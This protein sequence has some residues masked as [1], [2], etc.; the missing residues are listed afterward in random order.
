M[1]RPQVQ[2]YQ[3]TAY[4]DAGAVVFRDELKAASREDALDLTRIWF[5]M[6]VD[7]ARAV[8]EQDGV[9]VAAFERD[10]P[11]RPGADKRPIRPADS[12]QRR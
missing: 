10:R 3:F 4:N 9:S 12:A 11:W 8:L 1:G 5:T 2:T 6:G 7:R